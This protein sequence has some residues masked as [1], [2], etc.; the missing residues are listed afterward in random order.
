MERDALRILWLTPYLPAP[1]F[2][3]GTRVFNL[4]KALGGTCTIDLIA[5]SEAPAEGIAQLQTLCRTIEIVTPS[6]SSHRQKRLLQIKSL[7]SRRPSQYWMVHSPD[8]QRQI[9]RAL[10]QTQYDLVIVEHSFMGY[11]DLPKDIPTVLDQ[12]NVESEIL[13]RAGLSDRSLVRRAYNLLEYW[14]YRSDEQDI[15]RAAQLI[16]ATSAR[17]REAMQRWGDMP[18]CVVIPNGVDT[19][20]FFAPKGEEDVREGRVVFTGS[21]H[22]APN[23]EAMLYFVTEIWPLIRQQAPDATL[24]I[25]GGA[26]PPEI[27]RLGEL[28]HVSVAGSVPDVR[29]Y[30]ASAQVVVAPLR[31]GGGTRLKILEA[32]ATGRAIVSTT[33]GCEGLD[34]E[35][36][37]HLLVADDP[38]E[39]AA[40]VVELLHDPQQRT[41]LGQEGRRLVENAYDWRVLGARLEAALDDLLDDTDPRA[42]VEATTTHA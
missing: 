19:D 9:D 14:K 22:Y 27:V 25:I 32:M 20:Y 29:P 40:R 11:F 26:P 1:I 6:V 10:A 13:L 39:F 31:I 16:L 8:M 18:P 34:V 41:A 15:C 7:M 33:I 36:G 28:P 21:M 2:G 5:S 38:G 17:D 37:R 30:L 12:H 24:S 23:T 4:M 35:N 3:G 42:Q